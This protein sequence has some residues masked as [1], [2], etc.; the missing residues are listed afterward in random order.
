ML[1][2][3]DGLPIVVL[4]D[5]FNPKLLRSGEFLVQQLAAGLP[6]GSRVLDLG[7][8]SGAA[9]VV[10][11]RARLRTWSPS[12]STPRAVRCTRINALLNDVEP[13]TSAHGDLF[14]PVQGERFDV[15]LFNPPYYRGAPRDALDHAWRSP[16]VIERFAAELADHLTPARPRAAGALVGRRARRP[17]CDALERHGFAQPASSP[18]AT[19]VNEQMTRLPGAADASPLQPASS[20]RRKPVMPL[21]LLALGALLEGRHDYTI[22][23]GNLDPRPLGHAS[24]AWCARKAPTCSAS[25]SCPGRSWPTRCRCVAS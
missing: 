2:H 20:A 19:F 13:S 15:V 5:V 4:P 9:G 1:E 3:V 7:S 22:V 8:G 23:D 21:S 24:T 16:D 6:A 12:T 10:A 18:S 14:A 17:S 11:A 25:R